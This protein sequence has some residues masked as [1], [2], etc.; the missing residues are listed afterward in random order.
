MVFVSMGRV[1]YNLQLF[2]QPLG[3]LLGKVSS[4]PEKP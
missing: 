1:F 2:L 4:L 3:N